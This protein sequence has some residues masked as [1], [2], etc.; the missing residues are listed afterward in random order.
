M[1]CCEVMEWLSKSGEEMPKISDFVEIRKGRDFLKEYKTYDVIVLHF[2]FRGGFCVPTMK[3]SQLATSELA[4]WGEWRRRLVAS[5]AKFI[6]C[7][8]GGSEVSG[9]YIVDLN[10]YKV[11]KIRTD[12]PENMMSESLA[13]HQGL[14]IFEK[15]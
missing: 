15:L 1:R 7:Y 11:H 5:Q 9:T 4:S 14:W 13:H 3:R 8:G 2:L 6:F 12:A 10:G